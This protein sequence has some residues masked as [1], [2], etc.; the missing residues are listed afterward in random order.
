MSFTNEDLKKASQV[1]A[2]LVKQ[3]KENSLAKASASEGFFADPKKALLEEEV[4]QSASPEIQL[5]AAFV[6]E[7]HQSMQDAFKVLDAKLDTLLNSVGT[8]GDGML[9]AFEEQSTLMKA[10]SHAPIESFRS[11]AA[12]VP[13]ETLQKASANPTLEVPK[14]FIVNFLEK[15][16][17]EGR[18]NPIVVSTFESTGRLPEE[19]KPVITRAYQTK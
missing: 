18:L 5:I 17:E 3:Y 7:A 16:V 19:L 12:F 11:P 15:E 4:I 6:S 9:K 13:Q 14:G 8:V 1:C 10:A 2:E